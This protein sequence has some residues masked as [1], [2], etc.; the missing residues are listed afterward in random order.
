MRSTKTES[1]ELIKALSEAKAPSGFEDASIAVAGEFAETFAAVEE[2]H[3]RNLY[4]TPKKSQ[5]SDKPVFMLDA[6][7]DEVG[8][9]I[10]SITPKGTLHFLTLGR[11]DPN[12]LPASKVMVH[13]KFNTWIP[14]IIAAKPVHFMTE[15]EKGKPL[16]IADL[17]IDV[18]AVSYEDAVENFGVRI[19]EPAVSAVDF[20]YDEQHDIMFGKGF[21][22]RI[23]CAAM[24]ESVKRLSDKDLPFAVRGVMSAQE[25]V[26]ERGVQVA[27]QNTAPQVAICFEGC[28]ADDTCVE[29]YMVQTAIKRGPMLRHID[30]R[31]ITNPRYQRYALDLA[32]KLGIP[33]QDSVRSAGS[34]NGAAIHLTEKA[35]P[36]IVIGVPVRYAHTHYGISAYAD[37]DNAVKLACEILKRLDEEQIMSF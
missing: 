34:T 32:E 9:M 4:V 1:L 15:E 10:H 20:S 12:T 27:V 37:F 22:C 3:L 26:G 19:G 8:M 23:G 14:G 33:V 30:S 28:P 5:N 31:M 29:Q 6:H 2:D 18:G 17:V 35:V 16:N 7:G 21:D 11:W 25:E 13:T 36:V 24:L